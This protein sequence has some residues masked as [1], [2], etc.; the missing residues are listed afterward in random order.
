MNTCKLWTQLCDEHM[1][2][3]HICDD[4]MCWI[5]IIYVKDM[6]NTSDSQEYD[7]HMYITYTSMWWTY[8]MN[9]CV[10][11][12]WKYVLNIFVMNTSMW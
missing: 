7:E 8:V 1:W 2:W 12:W 11:M 4:H 10:Y 5:Y 6:V 9:T 3:I